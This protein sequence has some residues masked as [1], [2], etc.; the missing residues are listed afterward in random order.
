L[1]TNVQDLLEGKLS[2]CNTTKMHIQPLV[3]IDLQ[4]KGPR[5][6]EPAVAPKEYEQSWPQKSQMDSDLK[7]WGWAQSSEF[8]SSYPVLGTG[9]W[10]PGPQLL[11]ELRRL[12]I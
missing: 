1:N 11:Q 9:Q 2:V 8:R 5:Y 7:H 10:L 12:L 6:R 3:N 4:C